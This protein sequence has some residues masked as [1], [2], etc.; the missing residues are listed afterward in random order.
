MDSFTGYGI[1]EDC[2]SQLTSTKDRQEGLV[3]FME[4]RKPNYTGE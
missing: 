3:A 1:E 2:Y 4:K